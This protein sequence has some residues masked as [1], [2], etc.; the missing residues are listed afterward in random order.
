MQS[1]SGNYWE[2][3]FI[4]KRIIDKVKNDL[5]FSEFLSKLIVS[6][7]FDQLEINS[8][9]QDIKIINP[10]LSNKDF[11]DAKNIL[12]NSLSK[13]EK[14]LVIGDYDVDGCVSTSLLVKF[15]KLINKK[16]HYYIPNRFTDGYGANLKLI[17]KLIKDKPDLIIMVDCG[18]NSNESIKLLN[19]LK[20]KTLII[21]HHE[22]YNP[23]PKANCIINPK[24]KC[25]Y[26][27]LD[28][29][30][31]SSLVY[32]FI[33]FFIIKNKL[34]IKF[35][36]NLIY[37]LLA[38]VCDVMPLRK[39][40]RLIAIYALKNF[41]INKNFLFKKILSFNKIKRP[42]EIEDLGFLIGPILNSSGRINDANIV[43]KL[44]TTDDEYIKDEIINKFIHFNEKRKI[45]EN[46][47]IKE[48]NFNKII[49]KKDNVLIEHEYTINEGLIGI[50]ASRLKDYF[51]KPTIILTKS[52]NNYKASAR[53][54]LDFNIGEHIRYCVD[55]KI[56]INGGGHNLAAGFSIQKNNINKLRDYM[57]D[58]FIKKKSNK[59]KIYFSKIS[60]SSIN[61][62]FYNDIKR[63]GP[64]GNDN[65]NPYFLIEKL[66]IINSKVIQN[67]FI[68]FFVKSKFGKLIPGISFN[69][70][71]SEISKSLLYFKKEIDLIVQIKENYWNNKKNLQLIVKDLVRNP[72]KA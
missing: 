6:R 39:I 48:I 14:I 49:K 31:S 11:K 54:T 26:N 7:Q 40:N 19:E 1:V 51:N 10:F 52:V 33:D 67:K 23:Y 50:I 13:N 2:E 57:N 43:V 62:R 47:S 65:I 60:L 4:S 55:K 45:I 70:L 9:N 5:N 21:D 61:D 29:F 72:N 64:F 8:I 36:D 34:D 12:N 38:T 69:L 44:L 37:V 56:I 58:A 68:T 15:F 63:A 24:K 32:F 22:I 66:V 53:S 20:I 41:D 16:I 25:D 18:S 35:S 59:S 71:E 28:Y 3:V 42:L 17:K 46:E 27:K 30:C